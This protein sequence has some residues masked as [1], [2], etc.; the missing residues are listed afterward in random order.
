[1][2]R[3]SY[4][5]DQQMKKARYGELQ[6]FDDFNELVKKALRV[7]RVALRCGRALPAAL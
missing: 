5:A 6:F 7:G 3:H 4:E 2:H 1:V